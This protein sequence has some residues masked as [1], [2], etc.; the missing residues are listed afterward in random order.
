MNKRLDAT[1]PEGMWKVVFYERA[2][3]RIQID[4]SGPWLPNRSAAQAWADYFLREGY[5]VA[6]QSQDGKL[7]RLAPGLPG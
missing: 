3:R 6:L 1:H 4:R 7:D 5:H 2:G